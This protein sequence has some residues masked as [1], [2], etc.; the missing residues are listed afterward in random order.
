[1]ASVE[2]TAEEMIGA[3]IK[4]YRNESGKAVKVSSIKLNICWSYSTLTSTL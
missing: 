4:E 1:M 2:S 3:G